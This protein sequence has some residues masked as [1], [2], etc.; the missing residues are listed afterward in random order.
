MSAYK[1]AICEFCGDT[2]TRIKKT[3]QPFWPFAVKS[4]SAYCDE[5]YREIF[6]GKLPNVTGAQHRSKKGRGVED[7]RRHFD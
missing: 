2:A 7:R 5:C 4:C 6:Y 3:K 1:H